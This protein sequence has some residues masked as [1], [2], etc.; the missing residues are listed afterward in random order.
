MSAASTR[1]AQ[2]LVD[3]FPDLTLHK[4]ADESLRLQ[5]A[6]LTV[7][8]YAQKVSPQQLAEQ[9]L[10]HQFSTSFLVDATTKKVEYTPLLH[11]FTTLKSLKSILADNALLCGDPYP[12]EQH[13]AV[14][15]TYN[16]QLPT[17]L[18]DLKKA[19]DLEGLVRLTLSKEKLE[20]DYRLD[21]YLFTEKKFSWECVD[22]VEERVLEDVKRLDKYL[23]QIDVV[24]H[25][26]AV[27][28]LQA[29]YPELSMQSVK[30]FA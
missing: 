30:D 14:S 4:Q 17:T 12:G 7:T 26:A 8:V 19:A 13:G 29:R 20:K 1:L 18:G 10:I 3:L 28:K 25:A 24:G 15:L 11:H 23:V 22:E 16:A 5:T 27:K 2:R 9:Q 21:P 6:L